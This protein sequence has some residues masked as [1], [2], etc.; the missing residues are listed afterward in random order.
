[1]NSPD[2]DHDSVLRSAERFIEAL[3]ATREVQRF[4]EVSRRLNSDEEVQSILRTLARFQRARQSG[5]VRANE[6]QGARDAQA[7]FQS[8]AVVLDFLEAQNAVR[9]LLRETNGAVSEVLGLDFARTV[10]P[11]G[12]CC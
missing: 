12:E 9:A 10:G 6:V 4:L 5:E 3:K 11:A 8:N 7:R 1:M 2:H